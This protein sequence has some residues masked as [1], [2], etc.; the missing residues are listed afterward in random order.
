MKQKYCTSPECNT[1]DLNTFEYPT[2]LTI[3]GPCLKNDLSPQIYVVY[4]LWKLKSGKQM[5]IGHY[6]EP[7]N[8]FCRVSVHQKKKKSNPYAHKRKRDPTS[9]F[10]D[11]ICIY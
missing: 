10:R 9:L 3:Y 1:S 2:T 11:N 7:E 6:F 4:P 5:K 8:Y